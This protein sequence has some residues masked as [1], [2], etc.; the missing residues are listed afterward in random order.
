MICGGECGAAAQGSRVKGALTLWWGVKWIFSPFNSCIVSDISV[1]TSN[2]AEKSLVSDRNWK[3]IPPFIQNLMHEVCTSAIGQVLWPL[4]NAILEPFFENE[5]S[6]CVKPHL[7]FYLSLSASLNPLDLLCAGSNS[8]DQHSTVHF[9]SEP[10][11]ASNKSRPGLSLCA[12]MV[13]YWTADNIL[14]L[15]TGTL[16]PQHLYVL[17]Y[18][19][20]G[21]YN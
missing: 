7:I 18:S 19:H 1:K 14:S 13:K 16:T 20:C 3:L 2:M 6:E 10:I 5:N 8:K 9:L 17:W 4:Y 15:G 11:R 12:V 21:N